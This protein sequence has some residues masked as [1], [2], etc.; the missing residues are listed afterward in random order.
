MYITFIECRLDAC[1]INTRFFIHFCWMIEKPQK[2][3]LFHFPLSW[4]TGKRFR[5]VFFTTSHIESSLWFHCS[6]NIRTPTACVNFSTLLSEWLIHCSAFTWNCISI[7][8][9]MNENCLTTNNKSMAPLKHFTPGFF[10]LFFSP[11]AR[12]TSTST[13]RPSW[14]RWRETMPS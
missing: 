5:C 11:A 1:T 2:C 3:L 14:R 6:S 13:G 4:F 9:S 10:F 8:S 12:L 7:L